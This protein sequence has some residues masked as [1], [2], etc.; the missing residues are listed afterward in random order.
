[1]S[2]SERDG[3][4][5]K[6]RVESECQT[7]MNAHA[8]AAFPEECCGFM[9]GSETEQ[10]ARHIKEIYKIDNTKDA[11]RERRYLI[12]PTAQLKAER[13]AREQGLD[14]LGVY[15]SH[16]N[17][18]SRA[19]EFDRVHAMPFWSYLI[20]SCMEG[21][22]AEIQSWRLRDDRTQFDEEELIF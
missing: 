14:V 21:K 5:M 9:L 20:I 12:E 13:Y 6:I 1:M 17:H 16:P 4:P 8:E 3:N 18:P 11:N 19:S 10:G 15:H 2:D 22:T 7:T